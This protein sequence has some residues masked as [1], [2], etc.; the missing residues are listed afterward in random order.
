[1][2]VKDE[3]VGVNGHRVKAKQPLILVTPFAFG[4]IPAAYLVWNMRETAR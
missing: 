2:E 3:S 4:V 1:M